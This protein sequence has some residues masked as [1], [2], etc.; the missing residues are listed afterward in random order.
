MRAL[1]PLLLLA[2]CAAPTTPDGRYVGTVTPSP[3][4]EL[5]KTSRA[6]LRLHDG[7]ALFIPEEATWSLQGT[8]SP[9]GTLQAERTGQ[10]VNKKPYLTRFTG[11]WTPRSV[12]GTYTTPRCTYDVQLA[13]D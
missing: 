7:Q 6:I 2:A 4:S 9:A 11:T 10:G 13:R 1:I 3:P 8:V 5:C 12:A